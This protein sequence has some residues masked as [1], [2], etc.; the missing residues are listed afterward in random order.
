MCDYGVLDHLSDYA[1]DFEKRRKARER[2]QVEQDRID[3]EKW[4]KNFQEN[5]R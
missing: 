5:Q 3:A 2:A 4:R 1:D